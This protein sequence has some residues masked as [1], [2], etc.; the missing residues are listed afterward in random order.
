[1]RVYGSPVVCFCVCPFLKLISTRRV[2]TCRVI[3]CA[4]VFPHA[5]TGPGTRPAAASTTVTCDSLLQ[6]AQVASNVPGP[7]C[8]AVHDIKRVSSA[9][10]IVGQVGVREA[11]EAGH[12]GSVPYVDEGPSR[13]LD[14]QPLCHEQDER[15]NHEGSVARVLTRD[16][17]NGLVVH[18]DRQGLVP[19]PQ[20]A[21][22]KDVAH[23]DRV[24]HKVPEGILELIVLAVLVACRSSLV[25]RLAAP[26]FG[27][28]A[29]AA[30]VLHG[31]IY[32][33]ARTGRVA[34]LESRILVRPL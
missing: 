22:D 23:A 32:E 4:A 18:V 5:L 24:R 10:L 14:E 21:A 11:V 9:S 15:L 26:C 6:D 13:C 29:R 3:R 33:A 20:R 7:L 34:E 8:A 2:Y 25:V 12:D 30:R 19:L 17:T 28:S 1:M 27:A 16:Q 31:H